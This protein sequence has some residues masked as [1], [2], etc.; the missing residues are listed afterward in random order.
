MRTTIALPDA[1]LTQA[2]RHAA[3]TGRSL[4]AS[5]PMP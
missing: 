4:T 5:S 2:H 1:L 3:A